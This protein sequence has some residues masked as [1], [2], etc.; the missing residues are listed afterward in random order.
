MT[1]AFWR[2]GYPEQSNSWRNTVKGRCLARGSTARDAWEE[3]QDYLV[4]WNE[5]RLEESVR[6]QGQELRLVSLAF[7]RSRSGF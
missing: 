4:K 3:L 2:D 7:H 5:A 6:W 1:A